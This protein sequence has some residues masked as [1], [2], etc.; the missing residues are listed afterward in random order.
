MQRAIDLSQTARIF[1]S[2]YNERI[3]DIKTNELKISFTY[4]RNRT[5]VQTLKDTLQIFHTTDK[6]CYSY[7][8]GIS[9]IVMTFSDSRNPT[10]D[11]IIN[12]SDNNPI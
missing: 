6:G 9:V 3:H 8:V 2:L 11:V 12:L 1:D 10:Y 4:T 5:P 7:T